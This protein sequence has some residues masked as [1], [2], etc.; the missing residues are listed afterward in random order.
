MKK[1]FTLL[2]IL[3]AVV[4]NAQVPAYVPTNGLVGYWPFNG[5]A[6][7]ESGNGN[8]GTV[9]GATLTTDRFGNADS[10]YSF[11]GNADNVIINNSNSLNPSQLSISVWYL[12]LGNDM[13]VISKNNPSDAFK[14][15]YNIKH[16]DIFQGNLGLNVGWGIGNCNTANEFWGSNGQ[17][18][19]NQWVNVILTIDAS[20]VGKV[21]YN[22][23]LIST[24]NGA[25]LQSCNDPLSILKFG[26]PHWNN[27]SEWFNG[28]IDDI[29]IWNRALNQQEITNLYNSSLPQTSCLPAYVPTNGL[30]GY[31]PFCGNANDESGNGNNGTVNGAT[32]TT[33]RNGVTDSS[34]SFN[35][36]QQNIVIQNSNSLNNNILTVNVWALPLQDN[37]TIIE[38]SNPTNAT[39]AGFGITHNDYWNIQRGLKTMF[40]N[41]ACNTTTQPNVW[42]NYNQVVN[43]VWSMITISIDIDGNV[44]Q[45]IN[46]VLNYTETTTP[47]ISCNSSSSNIRIGGQHWNGDTEWF[48]GKI[49]DIA[50]W[51]RA[52]TQQEI[53]GLYNATLSTSAA[54]EKNE[55]LIYPNPV[56]TV[57]NINANE[58]EIEHTAVI[59]L[60]GKVVINQP[61]NSTQINVQDLAAG[62]YFVSITA[63]GKT[64]IQ[65]FVKQ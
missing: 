58:N 2:I 47:L 48:N 52:L 7:D 56:N 31:W 30:V 43:N 22:S 44:K 53:T 13:C 38:K 60:I 35:G 34:Y 15:S 21:Y 9:N 17:I 62:I 50:I 51:N 27:D 46:G 42:G 59:D 28:K 36:N 65:K 41:G 16:Q 37:I 26:G 6:N 25:V 40:G 39:E 3:S 45:Y 61:S 20:G 63:A 11:D 19:T 24:Y 12:A 49:D 1:I 23:N 33:D 18:P 64:S 8:N 54:I 4:I 14:F 10:A 5:N 32:L 55:I 29:G 57:L